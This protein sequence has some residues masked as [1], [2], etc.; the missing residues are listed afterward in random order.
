MPALAEIRA[1]IA[2]AAERDG[3]NPFTEV[4]R[5]HLRRLAALT[6]NNTLIYASGFMQNPD[7]DNLAVD[8]ED[9]RGFMDVLYGLDPRAGLDLLIHSPGGSPEAAEGVADY[10][11][12]H[13]AGRRIRVVVPC[14]AMSAATLLACAADAVMM[15]AH[16]GLGP[17]DPQIHVRDGEEWRQVAAHAVVQ[18]FNCLRRMLR[19]ADPGW[20]AA[21]SARYPPGAVNA[22][23][24]AAKMCERL[25]RDWLARR[26]F[27]DDPDGAGQAEKLAKQLANHDRFNSHSRRVSL[28]QAR[29]LGLRTERLEDDPAIQDAVLSIFHA[30]CLTFSH[31][32]IAKIIENHNGRMFIQ[33]Q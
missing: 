4:R 13:F 2:A 9:V 21:L 7:A 18:E 14:M 11:H 17:I 3:G 8:D 6:G 26:M 23:R 10:L 1:E 32:P 15:G 24:N 20:A 25:A 31:T 12:E 27:R 33:D 29:T 30:L 22:C 19:G 5:R 16:S 28:A